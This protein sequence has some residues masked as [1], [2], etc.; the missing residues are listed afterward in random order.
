MPVTLFEPP[1]ERP[2]QQAINRRGRALCDQAI[3]DRPERVEETRHGLAVARARAWRRERFR[4]QL[5]ARRGVAA[6]ERDGT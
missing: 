6:T 1:I 2:D 5:A 3:G 4:D